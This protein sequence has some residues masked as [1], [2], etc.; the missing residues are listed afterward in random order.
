MISLHGGFLSDSWRL[1]V[2]VMLNK[3]LK[4]PPSSP[5]A[6]LN[7]KTKNNFCSQTFLFL[8]LFIPTKISLGMC[9][10]CPGSSF[11]FLCDLKKNYSILL[12]LFTRKQCFLC[13][14]NFHAQKGAWVLRQPKRSKALI[15]L[16]YKDVFIIR[17]LSEGQAQFFSSSLKKLKDE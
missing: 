2:F 11:Q 16:N 4:T 6:S 1:R 17:L 7:K 14:W 15:S 9:S 5:L 3:Q 12:L 13:I 10:C 8:L